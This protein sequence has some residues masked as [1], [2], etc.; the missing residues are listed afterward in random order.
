MNSLRSLLRVDEETSGSLE[1]ARWLLKPP[2]LLATQIQEFKMKVVPSSSTV[3]EKLNDAIEFSG[4]C[5]MN[6]LTRRASCW[7]FT[8]MPT[9]GYLW[10]RQD[11]EL[12]GARNIKFRQIRAAE[13]IIPYVLCGLYCL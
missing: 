4:E 8:T 13:S 7:C 6:T 9:K 10:C 12:K 1:L 5:S 2:K 11:Q 3:L